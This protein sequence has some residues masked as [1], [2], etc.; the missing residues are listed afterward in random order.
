MLLFVTPAN[1]INATNGLDA[2]RRTRALKYG[3]ARKPQLVGLDDSRP[4]H[5]KR[6]FSGSAGVLGLDRKKVRQRFE[7]RFSA[8]RMAKDYVGIYR[9]LLSSK[10]GTAERSTKRRSR[11]GNEAITQS[12]SLS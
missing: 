8:T 1:A 3:S 2:A 5:W 9:S 4:H 10:P 11:N 12:P 7:Q 6:P